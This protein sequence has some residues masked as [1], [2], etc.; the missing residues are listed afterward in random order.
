MGHVANASPGPL[1]RRL[2]VESIAVEHNLTASGPQ[3]A[4]QRF[5]QGRF[6]HTVAA[7]QADHLAG[8]HAEVH[9]PEDMALAVVGVQAADFQQRRHPFSSS[10]VPR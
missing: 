4:D 3:Q 6:A 8:F 5:E 1:M 2:T 7:D 9:I 10:V